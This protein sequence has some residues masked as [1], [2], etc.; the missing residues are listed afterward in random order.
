APAGVT[1]LMAGVTKSGALVAV[2]LSLSVIPPG[3]SVAAF[4]GLAVSVLA[5]LT[6]T[7][8]NILALNQKELNR[9]LAYSSIAQ[10]GYVLLGFGLG[11]QYSL[12][13]GFAAGLLYMVAYA[14]MKSG[15]FLAA[16]LF[17]V[18]A[19]S[20]EISRMRGIGARRPVLGLAFAI[21]VLGLVGV[22]A[23]AGFLGKL[24]IF[25]AGM[26]TLTA[27][28]VG[29]VLVMA[30]NSALSLGYYVPVLSDLLFSGTGEERKPHRVSLLAAACIILFAAGTVILGFFVPSALLDGA[31]GMLLLKG[32]F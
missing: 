16:D 11:L 2:F 24:L 25:Q 7:A 9:L 5:V 19:G 21:F 15:A 26:G 20:V 14:V 27:W 18:E 6:M 10:M 28:G 13:A 8:G 29:L 3:S 1:A 4:L 17:A 32:G 22:P 12:A 31:A 30:A 23:T